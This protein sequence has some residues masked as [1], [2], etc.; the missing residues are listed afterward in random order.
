MSENSVE[1]HG[2]VFLGK[3]TRYIDSYDA[4]LLDPIPRSL[5]RA[6]LPIAASPLPFAGVD[7]WTAYEL[8]WLDARGKPLVAMAEFEFPCTSEAI[9]ESKS[10]KLYLNSF[11]QT[12]FADVGKVR[13]VLER[14]LSAVT[15]APVNVRLM[16][17]HKALSINIGH[18][19][20]ECIDGLDVACTQYHPDPSLLQLDAEGVEVDETLYSDLLK[21]NC[22]VTGQPDWASILIRYAG[23]A[24]DKASLLKYIVSYRAHK[25]FHEH[26]VESIFLD[27][28]SRCSPRELTVYA[29]Y[30]RRGGLDINP[31][32]TNCGE[33]LE[34]LRLVRQ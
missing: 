7:R 2:P 31:F 13:E 8:S 9:V 1:N 27:I 14:D 19:S 32:R 25:D 22:P 12:C 23:P 18:F 10:F 3:A 20:G 21:S 6:T 24:I 17:L 11:N 33:Q 28:L 26:C 30:T 5:A 16:D 34:G 29:R 4:S 15:G